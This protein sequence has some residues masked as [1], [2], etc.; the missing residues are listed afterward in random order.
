MHEQYKSQHVL[1]VYTICLYI[2]DEQKQFASSLLYFQTD[3]L[4][5]KN[6]YSIVTKC[7]VFHFDLCAKSLHSPSYT[8]INVELIY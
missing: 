8:Q 2:T 1:T 4:Y 6:A 3:F 7:V 5:A